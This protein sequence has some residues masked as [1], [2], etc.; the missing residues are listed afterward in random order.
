MPN[1]HMINTETAA[2]ERAKLL[3]GLEALTS[4][5]IA[6]QI[7]IHASNIP[8]LSKQVIGRPA[9]QVDFLDAPLKLKGAV[10]GF[11]DAYPRQFSVLILKET[12]QLV[13]VSAPY[14]DET[15]A[16]EMLDPP[17]A[18]SAQQQLAD[19]EEIY[20]DFPAM[21][22]EINFLDALSTVLTNGSGSPFLAKAIEGVYVMESHMEAP[23]RPI[24]AITLRGLPPFSAHGPG[25]DSVPE[26]QRNHM[27]NV[28][29][30]TTGEFLFAINSPH[31]Y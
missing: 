19:G 4:K 9:W 16:P 31:P 18:E 29:D 8:F 30:A 22:P 27:R 3:S 2:I 24:W 13:Q 26:W 5:I 7:V 23:A 28:L 14:L 1:G 25:A 10:S 20:T 11:Q 6:R 21:D 15:P 17:T 12:G